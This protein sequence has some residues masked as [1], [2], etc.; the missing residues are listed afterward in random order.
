M[1]FKIIFSSLPG[2]QKSW[3][4]SIIMIISDYVIVLN[5]I[6]C[7][8]IALLVVKTESSHIFKKNKIKDFDEKI[9]TIFSF[10]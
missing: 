6:V 10:L 9:N 1:L 2:P 3:L 8:Q 7:D 5:V 4:N